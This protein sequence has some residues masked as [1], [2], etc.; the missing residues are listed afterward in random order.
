[1]NE[2][3]KCLINRHYK[4]VEADVWAS[5]K[6]QAE[7][8]TTYAASASTAPIVVPSDT[9][10]V[11]AEGAN[12]C[13]NTSDAPA[14]KKLDIDSVAAI[15]G[16][17]ITADASRADTTGA[18]EAN[19]FYGNSDASSIAAA[20]VV[21]RRS[22]LEDDRMTS[23]L[24]RA[25]GKRLFA[26]HAAANAYAYVIVLSDRIH[27]NHPSD[28]VRTRRTS[29][30]A[31]AVHVQANSI[32]TA[33]RRLEGSE[34]ASRLATV[35]ASTANNPPYL[36]KTFETDDEKLSPDLRCSV[37]AS[38]DEAASTSTFAATLTQKKKVFLSDINDPRSAKCSNDLMHVLGTQFL[39][40]AKDLEI[41][42]ADLTAIPPLDTEGGTKEMRN[43]IPEDGREPAYLAIDAQFEIKK[44]VPSKT[45]RQPP[46]NRR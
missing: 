35:P 32:A 12:S 34:T 39:S 21:R 1:M 20:V 36:S 5:S 10:M 14:E 43:Q 44:L 26:V 22:H 7:R 28:A 25:L 29:D 45:S 42:L 4:L 37:H 8:D 38:L 46:S 41:T 17:I 6:A 13:S 33:I 27:S 11:E 24:D 19:A 23:M 40:D 31:A 15:S 16:D 2:A 3:E 30:H 9:D 18:E